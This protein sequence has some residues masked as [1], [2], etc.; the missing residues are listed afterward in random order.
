MLV[1]YNL[2]LPE[3]GFRLIK[4]QKILIVELSLIK[5]AIRLQVGY[6]PEYQ[7]LYYGRRGKWK[8]II[9]FG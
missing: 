6:R 8:N 7:T 1:I 5:F 4:I 2:Y 3:L 9:I